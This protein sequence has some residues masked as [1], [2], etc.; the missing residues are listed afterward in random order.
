MSRNATNYANQGG[1]HI[2]GV[3]LA[4]TTEQKPLL[5]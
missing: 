4:Q 1:A 2:P 5:N 3:P